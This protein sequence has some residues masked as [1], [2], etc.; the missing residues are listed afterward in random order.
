M[1]RVREWRWKVGLR[2][3]SFVSVIGL[4]LA[5]VFS[6]TQGGHI[7]HLSSTPTHPISLANTIKQPPVHQNHNQ[8]TNKLKTNLN[9][10]QPT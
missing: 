1:G 7:N 3:R 10:T 2:G 5:G 6:Q 8:L 4:K 9:L